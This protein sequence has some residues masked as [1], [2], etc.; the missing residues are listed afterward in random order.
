MDI[1]VGNWGLYQWFEEHGLELIHPNDLDAIR[2]LMPNG[3]LFEVT[4]NDG[5]Y[6]TLRYGNHTYRVNPS[7]FKLVATPP[8]TFG[9]VVRI[10]K[11]GSV[12]SATI[13]D[14]LWHFQRSEPYYHLAINGKRLTKQY[15]FKD[16]L[17]AD[18]KLNTA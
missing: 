11:G 12:I 18:E 1:A 7:L 4:D 2:N 9:D 10:R 8:F 14:I 13:C 6:L 3:K 17:D 16:F 5:E 15:W